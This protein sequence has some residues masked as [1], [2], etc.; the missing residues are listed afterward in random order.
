M[1][2]SEMTEKR[3]YPAGAILSCPADNCGLGL[4]KVVEPAS[5]EDLVV[6][7]DVKLARL[8]DTVPVRD[9]W[10]ILAC[11]FCGSRLLKD[12]KVHTLQDGWA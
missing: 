5:F 3:L 12:G 2:M 4:Y 10:Q 11:P 8:N 6:F 7:D 9:V 1:S